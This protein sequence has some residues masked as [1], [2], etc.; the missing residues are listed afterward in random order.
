MQLKGWHGTT[1]DRKAKILIENFSYRP[2]NPGVDNERHPNDLGNGCYFFLPFGNDSGKEIAT[3]FT[4]K[5]KSKDLAKEGIELA[6]INVNLEFENDS[7][8]FD[9]DSNDNQDLLEEV[10]ERMVKEIGEHLKKIKNDGAKRRASRINKNQGLVIEIFLD[11]V[12]EVKKEIYSAVQSTTYTE[13]KDVPVIDGKNGKEICVRN[14][15]CITI[16]S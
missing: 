9:L 14:T 10:R 8:I 16:I 6:L 15:K 13:L 5:Y 2:Y 1:S 4:K 11:L 3:A 12:A 7:L